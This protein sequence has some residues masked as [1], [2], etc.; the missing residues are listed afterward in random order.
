MVHCEVIL[1]DKSFKNFVSF[2][3]GF[4]FPSERKLLLEDLKRQVGASKNSPWVVLGDFNAIRSL[5][6][7]RGTVLLDA[8]CDDLN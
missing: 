6:E 1:T 8:H 2:A 3:Y 5:R 7:N 4:N